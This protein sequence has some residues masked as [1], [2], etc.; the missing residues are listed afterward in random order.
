MFFFVLVCTNTHANTQ[1]D[2]P[3]VPKQLNEYVTKLCEFSG[4][5]YEQH[6]LSLSMVGEKDVVYE[7]SFARGVKWS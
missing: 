5:T 2:F 7:H 4:F 6:S 3:S 1:T